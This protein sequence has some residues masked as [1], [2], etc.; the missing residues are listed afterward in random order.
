DWI[1]RARIILSRS[2]DAAFEPYDRFRHYERNRGKSLETLFDELAALRARNI[3]LVRSWNLTESD[4]DLTAKH[5][6]L[7]R[8]TLRQLFAA[9]VVHDLGH[10]AQV[11]RVMSKQYREETGPWVE[12]LPV[13]TDR[14]PQS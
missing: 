6:G 7:G 12:Y 13:L 11:S 14:E 9:W 8:V 1:P 3:D 5:P 4:L 2:A 10:I